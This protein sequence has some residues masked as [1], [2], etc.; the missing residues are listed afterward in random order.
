MVTPGPIRRGVTIRHATGRPPRRRPPAGRFAAMPRRPRSTRG[1]RR[2]RSSSAPTSPASCARSASARPRGAARRSVD[3]VPGSG[4]PWSRTSASRSAR[5]YAPGPGRLGGI[6]VDDVVRRRPLQPHVGLRGPLARRPRPGGRAGASSARPRTA[7][8]GCS[9]TRARGRRSTALAGALRARASG[10][11]TPSASTCRWSPRPRSPRFAWLKLGRRRRA[12][13]L[14]LRRRARSPSRLQDAQAKVLFTADGVSRRGQAGAAQAG[15]RR[16]RRRRARRCEHVRRARA[17]RHRRAD[18]PGR[19]VTWGASCAARPRRRRRGRR[20]RG[21]GPADDRL[22]LGH[23]RAAQGR[24][25][26]ARRVPGQDRQGGRLRVRPAGR[27]TSS[28][29]SPTW[30]GSWAPGR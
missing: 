12:G 18:A 1:C 22:H 24:G 4:T 29:G 10:G 5:P 28:S 2:P 9:P 20:H 30:A 26:H 14:R 23:D 3:D 15:R 19:D 6:A 13:L 16:G 21:R 27:T 8:C 17:P 7:R 11:A 25:P